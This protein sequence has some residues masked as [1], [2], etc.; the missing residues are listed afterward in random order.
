[1]AHLSRCAGSPSRRNSHRPHRR[2]RGHEV[3]WLAAIERR[4][5]Q[6]VRSRNAW[7]VVVVASRGQARINDTVWSINGG[8]INHERSHQTFDFSL[9]SLRFLAF[10]YLVISIV[11]L[12]KSRTT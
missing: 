11:H 1:M 12:N 8:Q 9:D 7:L 2:L 10:R 3:R 4:V 6:S 5:R